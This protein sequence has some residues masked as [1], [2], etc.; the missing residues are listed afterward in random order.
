MKMEINLINEE[1]N[2]VKNICLDLLNIL[3]NF[4]IT[5]EKILPYGLKPHTRSISWIVEQV[6]VQQMKY[7]SS[8]LGLSN[9]KYDMA[10][11]CLHDC[12]IYINQNRYFVNIKTHSI[13]NK[14]NKNDIAAVEKLYIQYQANPNYR[15]IYA[16]FGIEFNN[17]NISFD[18]SCL[19]CFTPQFMP[20]YVNPRND[21]IQATYHHNIIH[22]KRE[23]FLFELR[24][25]SKSIILT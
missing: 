21:K 8:K 2:I 10:D 3:P 18:N 7:N 25:N 11:T 5:D 12:E 17:I 6:I 20:I 4:N 14:K 22:R 24:K 19:H 23:D 16:C 15:L 9:V 1:L 13:K